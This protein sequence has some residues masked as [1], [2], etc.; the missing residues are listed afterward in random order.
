M[1]MPTLEDLQAMR[2]ART[3]PPHVLT[4]STQPPLVLTS[5]TQPPHVLISST[6]DPLNFPTA[7][8]ELREDFLPVF[9]VQFFLSEIGLAFHFTDIASIPFKF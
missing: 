1:I 2:Q 3:Q 7:A 5:S 4:S 8:V 9:T 6:Q